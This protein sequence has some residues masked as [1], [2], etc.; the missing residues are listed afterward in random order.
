[1]SCISIVLPL[2]GGATIRARVP[3]PNGVSRSMTRIV[4]GCVPVSRTICSCGLIGVRSSKFLICSYSSG[5]RLS[6]SSFET[7]RRP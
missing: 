5:V 4:M 2:R 7:S 1:M 3:L 6:I